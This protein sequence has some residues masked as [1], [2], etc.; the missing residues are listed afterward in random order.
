M[1]LGGIA[2]AVGA[3]VD[4]AVVMIENMHKHLGTRR[5]LTRLL[6]VTRA[7][8][9]EVA[10]ALFFL[11]AGD[12]R[13]LPAGI[14]TQRAGRKIIAPLAYTKTYAMAAAAALA[15]DADPDIDGLFHPRPHPP[16]NRKPA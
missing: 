11:A 4:A 1:S 16:R 15:G 10:P 3:M 12:Y 7:A 8:S 13:F 6:E 14:C 2:I 5:P 9:I